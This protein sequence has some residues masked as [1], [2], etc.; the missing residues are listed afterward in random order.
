MPDG[1][2]VDDLAAILTVLPGQPEDSESDTAVP[3]EPPLPPVK[4]AAGGWYC[5]TPE[6]LRPVIIRVVPEGAQV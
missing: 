2:P 3:L 4:T 6:W 5:S 1:T